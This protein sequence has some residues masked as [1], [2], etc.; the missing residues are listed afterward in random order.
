MDRRQFLALAALP[1][2]ATSAHAADRIVWR[3]VILLDGTTLSASQLEGRVVVVEF[4]A[5]WCP[6]CA[7]QNP[8]LE[9]L[10]REAGG[11]G[12]EILTFSIDKDPA[13]ARAYLA[14]HGYTFRAAQA[15]SETLRQFDL[16]KGLPVLF[17]IDATGRVVRREV[18]EMFPEDLRALAQYRRKPT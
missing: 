5:S 3:D 8:H 1:A 15:D 6:F 16:R 14:G 2:V 11:Q 9:A 7:R 12:L 18:G 13:M 4:W 17:V 10:Q